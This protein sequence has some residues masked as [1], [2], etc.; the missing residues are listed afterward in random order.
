MQPPIGFPNEDR[1]VPDIYFMLPEWNERGK[2]L[3]DEL[4]RESPPCR[5]DNR[6]K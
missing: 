3:R 1:P 4:A 2:A 6:P 5:T